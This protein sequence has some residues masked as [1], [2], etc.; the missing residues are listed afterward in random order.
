MYRSDVRSNAVALMARGFSLRSISVSTGINRA[1][2]REW[3][4]HPEGSVN[5]RAAC[6]RC[7]DSPTLPEPQADYAYLLGLYLGDGCISRAGGRDKEV[8]KLRIICA[9]AW[10]GLIRECERA[11]RSIRPGN[12]VAIQPRPGCAEVSS[13][14]RHWPCLFPQCGSGR[15]HLRTIELQ[16]WQRVIV[17]GNPGHFARGLFHSDGYRGINRVR[18]HCADGD[19]WYEYPRYLFTNESRDILRLCGETLDRLGVAWRFSRR[20]AISVARREAVARLDEFV[21]PKY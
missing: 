10:P 18:A 4:E 21:G 19:R 13:Y 6:P 20:N 15:K 9:D 17:L 12:K 3:R 7:A 2:L 8:W 1:T 5:P 11:T 16:P 14:S